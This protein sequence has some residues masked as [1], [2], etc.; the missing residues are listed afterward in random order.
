MRAVSR[1]TR[2]AR[3][4]ARPA[5]VSGCLGRLIFFVGF[6]VQ[7]RAVEVFARNC[8]ILPSGRQAGGNGGLKIS[9]LLLACLGLLSSSSHSPCCLKKKTTTREHKGSTRQP[10]TLSNPA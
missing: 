7:C 5:G 9:F 4:S 2:A 3:R 1:A 8:H 10:Q 6:M